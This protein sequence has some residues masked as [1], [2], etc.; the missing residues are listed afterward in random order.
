MLQARMCLL[1][2]I[3]IQRVSFGKG[4][5]PLS[6][7]RQKYQKTCS[8]ETYWTFPAFFR[9]KTASVYRE[10][11]ENTGECLVETHLVPVERT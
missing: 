7:K 5:S 1:Q 10:S 6:G 2:Y 4:L 11:G 9:K 8:I 3:V